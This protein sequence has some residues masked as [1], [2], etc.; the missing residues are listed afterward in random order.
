MKL[1][2]VL[3]DGVYLEANVRGEL[4]NLTITFMC[5]VLIEST[6]LYSF[7]WRMKSFFLKYPLKVKGDA[8]ESI[9]SLTPEKI[10]LGLEI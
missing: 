5:M 3:I 2:V 6:G 8:V 4:K 10:L 9:S 1:E 7:L